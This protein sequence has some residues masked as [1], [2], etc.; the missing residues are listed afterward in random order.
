[1]PKFNEALAP[2]FET[3]KYFLISKLR[4]GE[5]I[6][7]QIVNGGGCEG[8]GR[9]RL[10]QDHGVTTLICSGIKAFYRELLTSSGITVIDSVDLNMEEA[11]RQ[12][13]AGK[14]HPVE[15]EES[16]ADMSVEIPHEDL[17]CW[18]REL[19][20]SHGFRILDSDPEP[21]F[22][23]DLVAEMNCPICGR[24]IRVAVCCGAHTYRSDQE[25]REFQ[26][27]TRS[28]YQARVY[29]YPARSSVRQRCFEYG[30]QVIDPDAEGLN[31]DHVEPG[32]I[33]L[34]DHAIPGHEAA[35]ASGGSE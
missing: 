9:V 32:R 34:L 31:Q 5:L 28:S 3:A 1:M 13:A 27:V 7:S 22:P 25:I 30:I 23:I 33:P 11:L 15:R 17:V 16:M 19:F 8:F 6:S 26:H 21:T 35:F 2:C 18:A 4:E 20:E 12:F 10:L 29:V 14:L 24:V